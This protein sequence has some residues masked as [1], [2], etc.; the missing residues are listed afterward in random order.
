MRRRQGQVARESR[1]QHGGKQQPLETDPDDDLIRTN[2]DGAAV[3]A[4]QCRFLAVGE[5]VEDF[6]ASAG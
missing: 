4:Q 2:V 1:V 6:I 3:E 5:P